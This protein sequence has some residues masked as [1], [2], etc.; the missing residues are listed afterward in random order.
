MWYNKEWSLGHQNLFSRDYSREVIQTVEVGFTQKQHDTK[1]N[2]IWAP[3]L[4]FPPWGF[5]EQT[6]TRIH[7][8]CEERESCSSPHPP[9]Q[10]FCQGT[11]TEL[12]GPRLWDMS[13]LIPKHRL[14]WLLLAWLIRGYTLP[15][16]TPL[17]I[18]FYWLWTLMHTFSF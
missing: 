3:K 14:M 10:E 1:T 2:A 7:L 4:W 5:A 6:E 8:R 18:T 9:E 13:G 11:L 15:L 17:P 12:G 16:R